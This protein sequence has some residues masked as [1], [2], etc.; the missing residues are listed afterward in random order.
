MSPVGVCA[1]A[2]LPAN[3]ASNVKHA[4][5]DFAAIVVLQWLRIPL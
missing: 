5:L 2:D 4:G 1:A 3:L